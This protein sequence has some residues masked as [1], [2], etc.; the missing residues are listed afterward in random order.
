MNALR[1]IRT[2]IIA[3]LVVPFV[4]PFALLC[5]AFRTKRREPTRSNDNQVFYGEA[6]LESARRRERDESV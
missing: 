5:A 1:A 6:D 2:L 3:L 4:V